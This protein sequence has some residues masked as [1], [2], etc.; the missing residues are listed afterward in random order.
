[1]D[2][3]LL[4]WGDGTI[5]LTYWNYKDGQDICFILGD[6]GKAYTEDEDD[7]RTGVDLITRLRE[8]AIASM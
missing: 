7:N 2:F 6:D 5:R 8:I 4:A 1:M 3:E